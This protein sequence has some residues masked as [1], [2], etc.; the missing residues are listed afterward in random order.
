MQ[1]TISPIDGN[2]CVERPLLNEEEAAAL[3]EK[4]NKAFQKWKLV[5]LEERVKIVL[6]MVD[7]FVSHKDEIAREITVQMGRKV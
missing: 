1:R 2:V 5:P 3:L 6:K 7:A 4:G